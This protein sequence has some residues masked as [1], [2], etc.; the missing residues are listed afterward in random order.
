MI[1]IKLLNNDIGQYNLLS[2]EE[3]LI[4]SVCLQSEG[5]I[6][7][8]NGNKAILYFS[9]KP[10]K[11]TDFDY[12]WKVKD[13]GEIFRECINYSQKVWS[14][15]NYKKQCLL[16]AKIFN[17]NHK[18]ILDEWKKQNDQELKTQIEKLT[19]QIG[20]CPKYFQD[21]QGFI[22]IYNEYLETEMEKYE[23]FL[24]QEQ[25]AQNEFKPESKGYALSADKIQKYEKVISE[26]KT[27]LF[28]DVY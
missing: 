6:I 9:D 13:I 8:E 18:E 10:E 23:N 25:N 16:F 19:A 11:K 5:E 24:K 21:L 14:S 17:A 28:K 3:S 12:L 7:E 27:L 26:L 1:T 4:F 15:T 2:S 20:T 22:N